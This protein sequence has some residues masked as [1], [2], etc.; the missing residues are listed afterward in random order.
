MLHR[1]RGVLANL[2]MPDERTALA[3]IH[4]TYDG[5]VH[6]HEFQWQQRFDNKSRPSWQLSG[7]QDDFVELQRVHDTNIRFTITPDSLLRANRDA[8]KFFQTRKKIPVLCNFPVTHWIPP[9]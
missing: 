3:E 8:L 4:A 9:H 6:I 1:I 2:E 5:Q 7:T